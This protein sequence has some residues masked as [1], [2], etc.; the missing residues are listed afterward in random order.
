MSAIPIMMGSQRLVFDNHRRT[1][2]KAPLPPSGGWLIVLFLIV[3]LL[4]AI[5]GYSS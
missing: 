2:I 5:L 3:V 4:I 1:K